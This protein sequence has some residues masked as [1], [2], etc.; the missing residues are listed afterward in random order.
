MWYL[1]KDKR[2]KNKQT[3]DPKGRDHVGDQ[4]IFNKRQNYFIEEKIIFSTVLEQL[5]I[6]LE[7]NEP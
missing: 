5:D 4:P 7:E 1:H 3:G 2:Y 6:C